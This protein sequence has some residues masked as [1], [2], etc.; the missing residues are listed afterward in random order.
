MVVHGHRQ[1][2]LGAILPDHVLVE[3]LLDF[4]WLGDLVGAASGRLGFVIL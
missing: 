1:L 2:L 4:Q 3:E